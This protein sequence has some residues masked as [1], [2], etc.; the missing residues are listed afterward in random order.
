M[1]TIVKDA[2]NPELFVP[3]VSDAVVAKRE[4]MNRILIGIAAVVVVFIVVKVIHVRME[5]K[6]L[7][8]MNRFV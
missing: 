2:F 4:N 3:F 6:K 8:Q 5:E 1:E 7:S